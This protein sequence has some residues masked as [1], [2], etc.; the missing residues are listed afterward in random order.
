MAMVRA[1]APVECSLQDD[2]IDPWEV[3][4]ERLGRAQPRQ[5]LW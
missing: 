1:L 2:G 5:T 3:V 4:V